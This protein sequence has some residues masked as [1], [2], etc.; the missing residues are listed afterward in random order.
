MSALILAFSAARPRAAESRFVTA[1]R[2]LEQLCPGDLVHLLGVMECLID[3][4]KKRR[5]AATE[6]DEEGA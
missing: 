2:R 6:D 3:A 1:A 4:E 5:A